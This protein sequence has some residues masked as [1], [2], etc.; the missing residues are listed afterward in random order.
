MKKFINSTALKLT[1]CVF[2]LIPLIFHLTGF[3]HIYKAVWYNF[4]NIDDYKIFHNRIITKSHVTHDWK[5][6]ENFNQKK[7]SSSSQ[8]LLDSLKTTAFL[9]IKDK[10]IE[11]EHYYLDGSDSTHTNSFSV[12]KSYVSALI[13]FAIQDGKIKSLDQPIGDFIESFKEGEKSKITIRDV[14]MMSSGLDWDESYAGPFS[15]TTKAYYGDNLKKIIDE[16]KA[17]EPSG[18]TFKYLSGNTQVLA[19]IL[20]KAT[21]KSLSEYASEKIWKPLGHEQ[22]A[23]WSLDRKDGDE[24]AYCCI[25]TNARDFA[26]IGQFYLDSGKWNNQQLLNKEYILESIKPNGVLDYKSKKENDYYGL[27]WWLIPHNNQKIFYARGI[28]GQYI[29]IIPEKKIVI[30]RLGHERGERRENTK[31]YEITYAIIDE[32]N[33]LFP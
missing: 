32:V 29:I 15:I 31:H 16:Q 22:N 8:H 26:R 33:R 5:Y 25:S 17:I 30:V 2:L 19:F 27:H 9:V 24:K 18:K 7:L 10:K 12:A 4:V 13:G 14:L 28:L 6:S 11:L 20:K 23:F 21:G 3:N 1:F